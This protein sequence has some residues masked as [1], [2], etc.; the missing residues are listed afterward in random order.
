[1]GL[2]QNKTAADDAMLMTGLQH[3]ELIVVQ[4]PAC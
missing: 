4:S 2:H 3:I 1:M